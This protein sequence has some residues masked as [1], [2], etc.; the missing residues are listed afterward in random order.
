MKLYRILTENVDKE[1]ICD[2]ISKYFDGFT[3]FETTGYWRG[4]QEQSLCIEIMTDDSLSF[5]IYDIMCPKICRHNKQESVL[6][7]ELNIGHRFV[8]AS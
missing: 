6:V 5:W 8:T 2:L 4:C 1:W 7:Q 3:V